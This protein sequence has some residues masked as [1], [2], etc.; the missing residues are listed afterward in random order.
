MERA[1]IMSKMQIAW[2]GFLVVG[3]GGVL[4]IFSG[5]MITI[6]TK[7]QMKQ[8]TKKIEGA[9]VQ[10]QFPGGGSMNPIVEYVVDGNRYIAKKKFRGIL[11]KRISGLSVHVASGVYEDEK[12]WLHI[13]TGAI[14]NLRELAEQLWPIGSKMSVYY[15]PNNPKRCYVDRPVLG[16]TIS[17][18]FIVTGLIILVL[19]VLVLC[20]EKV[21]IKCNQFS[22]F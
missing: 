20:Q 13:K 6:V 7:K 22:L 15:N 9:V 17:A 10:Y 21:Q 2:L 1:D 8:C 3:G 18:V 14:A 11:T 16:S 5:V 19:S 4:F 12:G